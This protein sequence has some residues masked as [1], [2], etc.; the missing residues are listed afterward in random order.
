MPQ[1]TPRQ[2]RSRCESD[3]L[4]PPHERA[5]HPCSWIASYRLSRLLFA[6]PFIAAMARGIPTM[7]NRTITSP[8]DIPNMMNLLCLDEGMG[9]IRRG[10]G[11]CHLENRLQMPRAA[12]LVATAAACFAM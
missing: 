9:R 7:M 5:E 8:Q 1:H 12:G 2:R 4:L 3:P 6:G 11:S 10:P